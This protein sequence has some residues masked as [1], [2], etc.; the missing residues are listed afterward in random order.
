VA[1]YNKATAKEERASFVSGVDCL[2]LLQYSGN[3]RCF[4]YDVAS[5]LLREIKD[6]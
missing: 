3:S 5:S 1:R 2:K 6:A 4:V